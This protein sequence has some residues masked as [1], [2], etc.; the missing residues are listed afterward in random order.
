[1]NKMMSLATGLVAIV[2]LSAAGRADVPVACGA[3]PP[4][5]TIHFHRTPGVGD[6][7]K[8]W[9]IDLD[10]QSMTADEVKQFR[11]MIEDAGFFDLS[12]SFAP[13]NVPDPLAGYDLTVELDGRTHHVWLKDA[14]VTKALK[15]LI[16][17]LNE[18]ASEIEELIHRQV[19]PVKALEEE[20]PTVHIEFTKS[21]G[22]AGLH[23]PPVVVDSTT[24]TVEENRKLSQ[25]IA[26]VRFFDLKENYPT[27][28]A[29]LFGY[30]ITVELNGKRHSV[31]YSDDT[32]PAE[33]KPLLAWLAGRTTQEPVVVC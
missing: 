1:M 20:E 23:F 13:P 10:G 26:E 17:A 6:F 28:G 25:L 22:I 9:T 2:F 29:D 32:V 4:T 21:G 8:H 12:S 31:S 27:H 11:K 14:D 16:D 5:L 7:G 18:R 33:L 24:L 30:T 19:V 15:P 3:A